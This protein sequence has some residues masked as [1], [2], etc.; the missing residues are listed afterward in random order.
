[1]DKGTRIGWECLS[2]YKQH[3]KGPMQ[4]NGLRVSADELEKTI[5]LKIMDKFYRERLQ[6]LCT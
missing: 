4:E 2:I 1:M 3:V 5:V 6:E